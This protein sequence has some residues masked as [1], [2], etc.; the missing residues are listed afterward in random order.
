MPRCWAKRT[1]LAPTYHLGKRVPLVLPLL[2]SQQV[3][4][5]HDLSMFFSNP[6][7]STCKKTAQTAMG[8]SIVSIM[9]I[10]GTDRDR[11]RIPPHRRRGCFF[12]SG[13]RPYSR[14]PS[15]LTSCTIKEVP[16]GLPSR[17]FFECRK[18]DTSGMERQG[19]C[20]NGKS[21]VDACI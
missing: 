16:Q 4:C 3:L 5:G 1:D 17:P 8:M 7:A 19:N 11:G 10:N 13:S 9:T 12:S 18:S 14:S 15:S 2:T 6:S 20:E 21:C